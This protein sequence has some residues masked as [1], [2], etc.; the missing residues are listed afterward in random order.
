MPLGVLSTPCWLAVRFYQLAVSPVLHLIPGAGCR[1]YP[2]CS[3]YMLEAISRHGALKGGLMG[4]CR[5]LRCN[6]M[7]AGGIDRVP[8]NF[9]W[10]KLFSQNRVDEDE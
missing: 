6:P 1:F 7:C 10:K 3:E 9:S 2:T 5:I 8:K 4:F